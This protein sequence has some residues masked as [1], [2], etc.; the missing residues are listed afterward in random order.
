MKALVIED[1]RDVANYLLKGLRESDFVVDHAADGKEGMMMAASEEYDIMIV[2]R[3]LPGM[4][5]LSIIKTV[6]AT[7]NQTPVLILRA[8]G[9]VDDR[10]EGLRGGGDDYLTKPFHREEL[11]ARIH[12]IIRR[13]KG[14]SQ[15]VIHTG[16]IAVNLDAKTVS[17]NDNPVHLTGKEYQMLELLS[18]RKGTTLTKEMFLNHLYGGMDEPELKIIDVFIC[19]LRKKLSQA[20]G[21]ENYIETVWGRGYV[22]RDPE[23]VAGSDDQVA[24]RA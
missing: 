22:L 6:R 17:V 8:L 11:V 5:G 24:M 14:H 9:D 18:L 1:D 7:G 13:S 4:D 21:G 19:K 16:Q 12:A 20:T 23:P 15:S 3:M 10:V 2:D